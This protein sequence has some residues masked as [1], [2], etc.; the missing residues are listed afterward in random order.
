MTFLVPLLTAFRLIATALA[1]SAILI[2]PMADAQH[3]EAEPALSIE[4]DTAS[5]ELSE[6]LPY[7]QEQEQEHHSH[8]CGSCHIHILRT[9][10]SPSLG[11][12]AQD[13]A[14]HPLFSQDVI[15]LAPRS[16]YRPP[17]A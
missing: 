5:C 17:R 7:E 9:D 16:L 13:N 11:V 6:H 8:H 1:V 3:F 2:V 10:P 15:S 14:V 12:S 4:V